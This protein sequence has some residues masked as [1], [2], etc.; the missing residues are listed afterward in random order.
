MPEPTA[1][2][3][4]K[5]PAITRVSLRNYKS[6]PSCKIDMAPLTI[7][8]GSNGA[9]KSNFLDALRFTSQALRFSLD[10]ALRE[11][12]GINEV[13]RRSRGHPNHFGIRLEFR[14]PDIHGWYSFEVGAKPRGRYF[15]RREECVAVSAARDRSGHFR[16]ENGQTTASSFSHPP[17]AGSDR[18]YL[19]QVAGYPYFRPVYDALAGMG[20]YNFH[21]EQIREL[22]SPDP[23]DLL[24]PDGSNIASVLARLKV[25]A[26]ESAERM[27]TYLSKV[28]PGTVGMEPKT[29]GPKLTLE[30]SQRVRGDSNP[31]R[32]LANNVSDG[33]LR[34]LGVL[35][36]LYQGSG[37]ES[38]N[39]MLVGI[40]EPEGALHP[41]AAGLLADVLLEASGRVQVVITSHSADLLDRDTIPRESLVAVVSEDGETRLAPLDEAGR[42]MLRDHLFTAG[43]LLRIDQLAPDPELSKPKPLNLFRDET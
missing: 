30:F 28:V 7:L 35:V 18:L 11:R 1:S 5:P 42:S 36:A 26:P 41:A 21:P 29:V 32:F 31:W 9:G 23:G 34:V 15:V 33:T 8:V 37:A 14:L 39:A 13:R 38:G 4:D 27:E 25:E 22:Q 6:I 20:F 24:K 12:G 2:T 43:E 19:M 40:E 16:V 3:A 10:H 17:G